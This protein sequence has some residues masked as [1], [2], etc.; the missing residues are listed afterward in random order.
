MPPNMQKRILNEIAEANNDTTAETIVYVPN[1]GNIC[2]D[3][4]FI[5]HVNVYLLIL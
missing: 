3:A 2:K 4:L 1:E 5:R